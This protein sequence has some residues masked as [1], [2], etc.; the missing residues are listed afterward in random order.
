MIFL[1]EIRFKNERTFFVYFCLLLLG[2]FKCSQLNSNNQTL[3]I[4]IKTIKITKFLLTISWVLEAMQ[5]L[6]AFLVLSQFLTHFS[7]RK[8]SKCFKSGSPQ[9]RGPMNVTDE[10]DFSSLVRPILAA[11]VMPRVVW[12]CRNVADCQFRNF[13]C[14]LLIAD[15]TSLLS[16][17]VA[18][19]MTGTS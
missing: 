9:A 16:R 13:L 6:N 15:S 4:E 3:L 1:L 7:S 14:V 5:S 2:S 19:S 10:A 17:G 8:V 11:L 18:S 12:S